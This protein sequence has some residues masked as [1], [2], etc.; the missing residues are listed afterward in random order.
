M[1]NKH[2]IAYF[3][4]EDQ[5]E[6]VAIKL[7]K[8]KTKDISVERIPTDKQVIDNFPAMPQSLG[9]YFQGTLGF[10]YPA[11]WGFTDIGSE[12]LNSKNIMLS[13]VA[14]QESINDAIDFIHQGRGQIK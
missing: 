6:D 12:D 3:D 4:T 8:L 5:A 14:S 9:N 2:I 10:V 13:F 1:N 11:A 7:Q